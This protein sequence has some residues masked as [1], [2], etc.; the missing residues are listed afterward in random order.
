M[1]LSTFEERAFYW[2]NKDKL[3]HVYEFINNS[4]KLRKKPLKTSLLKKKIKKPCSSIEALNYLLEN[5][6]KSSM[7]VY[8]ANITPSKIRKAGIVSVKVLIPQLQPMYLSEKFKQID[9]KRINVL[10]NIHKMDYF[11]KINKIN[12]MPHFFF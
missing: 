7:D 1:K 9:L 11:L 8:Y 6:S 3:T 4:F 5:L 10:K 2:S 12:N